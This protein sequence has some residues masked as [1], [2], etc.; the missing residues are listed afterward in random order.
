MCASYWNLKD[1]EFICPHCGA[2]VKDTLQTH[3]MGDMSFMEYYSIGEKVPLL[4]NMTVTLRPIGADKWMD[5]FIGFC[6]DCNGVVYFG[7]QITDGAVIEVW[8]IP[9]DN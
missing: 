7:A 3:F 9:D 1:V 6:D 8:P 2:K 5:D 4:G